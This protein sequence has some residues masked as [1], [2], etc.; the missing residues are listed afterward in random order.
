MGITN[1]FEPKD[2][3]DKLDYTVLYRNWLGTDQITGSAWAALSGNPA[4]MAMETETFTT[5][6]TTLWLSSGTVSNIYGFENQIGTLG[7][8]EKNVTILIPVKDE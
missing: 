8:R 2:P 5:G 4:G 3:R 1:K 6:S 7:G